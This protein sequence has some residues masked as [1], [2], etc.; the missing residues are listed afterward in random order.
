MVPFGLGNI[1]W[2]GLGFGFENC[3]GIPLFRAVA[4]VRALTM[5]DFG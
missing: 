2:K 5:G 1:I 4:P 3:A